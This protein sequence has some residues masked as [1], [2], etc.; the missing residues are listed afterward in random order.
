[1][2]D[3]VENPYSRILDRL[4]VIK[5]TRADL[6]EHL[7]VTP[8]WVSKALIAETGLEARF[9]DVAEYLGVSIDWLWK[10]AEH[11]ADGGEESG[12]Y[13]ALVQQLSDENLTLKLEIARMRAA[14]QALAAPVS[15]PRAE[16]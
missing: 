6:A 16:H 12:V 15:P 3:P 5:R 1:M 9:V 7:G 13:R 14:R 2:P 8:S 11:S 4:H 10:G